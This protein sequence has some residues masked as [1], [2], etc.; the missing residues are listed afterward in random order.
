MRRPYLARWWQC[1]HCF[2]N[3]FTHLSDETAVVS[4][5]TWNIL[6]K[7]RAQLWVGLISLTAV[8]WT[9]RCVS[10]CFDC[11]TRGQRSP[12]AGWVARSFYCT[13]LFSFC[14]PFLNSWRARI[15]YYYQRL[16]ND[17]LQTWWSNI[18]RKIDVEK[19][20]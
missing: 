5:I 4:P 8:C 10:Q 16:F 1:I 12:A 17:S 13:S 9:M 20:F 11:V 19:E 15:V 7:C 3:T 18:K 14:A 6:L 2:I